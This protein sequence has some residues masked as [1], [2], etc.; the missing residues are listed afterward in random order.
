AHGT[1]DRNLQILWT[2]LAALSNKQGRREFVRILGFGSTEDEQQ[3]ITKESRESRTS[4]TSNE[5]TQLTNIM[6]PVSYSSPRD[7]SAYNKVKCY[8]NRTGTGQD[9]EREERK[10]LEI[11]TERSD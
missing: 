9:S 11:G 7:S 2:F 6:S 3:R 5:V 1:D 10:S 8:K 4:V